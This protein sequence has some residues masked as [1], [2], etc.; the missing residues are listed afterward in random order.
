MQPQERYRGAL[1]GLAVG[2]ALGA[3][4]EFSSPGSFPPLEDLVGGGP[5]DLNPGEWT[6]DTAM[7]LC[8]AE[9]LVEVGG[10]DPKDQLRRYLRWY[11][12]GHWSPKGYCFDIGG[13]TREALEC[14]AATGEPYPGPT[15]E[16]SAGNGS[17][18][19]LA[20]V[21]LAYAARPEEALKYA[22]LSSRTTHGARAA[23]DACRYFAGLLVGAVR[24]EEKARLLEPGYAPVPE[25]WVREPLHPEV[26]EVAQG[27]FQKKEPPQIRASGYVVRTLEAALWAFAEARDFREGALLAANL[28][29][30]ADTVAAVYGQIAGAYYGE[31]GIPQAWRQKLYAR[32]AIERLADR[33]YA[34]SW[35]RLDP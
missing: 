12:E 27:S 26:A 32:E 25:A 20:P 21:A 3:A 22:A 18:M 30:D 6:D 4:V 8:L 14:F 2:D 31:E 34:L 10:F 33:L 24:G 7:A 16:F 19:R 29:E 1:L 9:S 35:E 13:T 28:G 23:V 11:R 15:H 17:L 5:H